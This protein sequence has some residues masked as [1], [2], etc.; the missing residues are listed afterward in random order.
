MVVQVEGRRQ[1]MTGLYVDDGNVQQLFPPNVPMVELELDHLRIVCAL[2]PEFWQGHAEIHDDRLLGWLETKRAT[3]KLAAC[4]A[5]VLLIPFG[6]HAI[7]VLPLAPGDV[8]TSQHAVGFA[9]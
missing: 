7:R 2:E 3:G 8:N 9:A 5:P 4:P 1:G 6:D